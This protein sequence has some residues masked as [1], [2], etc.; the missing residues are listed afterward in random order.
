MKYILPS[1]FRHIPYSWIVLYQLYELFLICCQKL[2]TKCWREP[3]YH[4]NKQPTIG[5]SQN[6]SATV[7]KPSA[8]AC[9]LYC[10]AFPLAR[11]TAPFDDTVSK[12]QQTPFSSFR[13]K[14]PKDSALRKHSFHVYQSYLPPTPN[15]HRN[16]FRGN[17]LNFV[18][19]IHA[20]CLQDINHNF[21]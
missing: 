2:K 13:P 5:T 15:S 4:K 16:K 7:R 14:L 21:D 18:V 1:E 8:P 10:Q 12:G 11:K 17:I 19:N 3:K 20:T 6:Y 9:S